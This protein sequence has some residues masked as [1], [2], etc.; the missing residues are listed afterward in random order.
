MK[1][2]KGLDGIRIHSSI[3]AGAEPN[4]HQFKCH[5]LLI[6]GDQM[7]VNLEQYLFNSE[8]WVGKTKTCEVLI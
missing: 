6:K 8:N 5:D 4:A 3:A 1:G 7:E 2:I